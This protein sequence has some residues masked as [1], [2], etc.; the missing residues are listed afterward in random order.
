MDKNAP[1]QS[2]ATEPLDPPSVKA[3]DNPPPYPDRD[4]N[5]TFWISLALGLIGLDHFYLRSPK[6]GTLK[7][8]T[9]GGLGIWWLW[10][11]F[12]LLFEKQSVALYGLT[13]P[14]EWATGIGQ[15]QISTAPT[16]IKQRTDYF[17]WFLSAFLDIFGITALIEGRPAAFLRRLIDGVLLVTFATSATIFGG[18]MAIIFAF[19]TIVPSFF[20]LKAIFN[21]AEL[22]TKGV[23][24]P[25]NL[26]KLLNFFESWTDI[27]GPNATAVV[28]HDFGLAAVDPTT[29][30]HEFGYANEEE[31][32]AEKEAAAASAKTNKK[33]LTS[34]PISM[35]LG[36]VFGG[37]VLSVVNLFS[38]IPTVKMGLLAADSYFAAVR[39]SRGETPD[40][41]DIGGFLP[42]G[43]GALAEKATEAAATI[44][45]AQNLVTKATTALNPEHLIQGATEGLKE[46]AIQAIQQSGGA[47]NTDTLSTES[48]V[49]GAT[50][51]AL[52]A[53]GAIKMTVDSL[54]GN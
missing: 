8:L 3:V 16:H 47:R 49:L 50:V 1:S 10:D 40:I 28:R 54:V 41:P 4:I 29:A 35:L 34:W 15:G 2:Q 45:K 44:G 31:I 5:T 13:A 24:I 42:P 7:L 21:P 30:P 52:I 18:L 27:I 20:T 32:A 19:F 11:V 33:E 43:V 48:M 46:K 37:L 23:H 6:T 12:Q 22:A 14:F 26:V 36:N 39:M 25:P 51:L 38:F 9:F 53:G 17:N